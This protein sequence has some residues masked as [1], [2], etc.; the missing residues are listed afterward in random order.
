M[1]MVPSR[2]VPYG[3]SDYE[4]LVDDAEFQ[5]FQAELE[6]LSEKR[7]E[8]FKSGN[9]IRPLALRAIYHLHRGELSQVTQ[10]HADCVTLMTAVMAKVSD[11]TQLRGILEHCMEA[12]ITSSMFLHFLDTGLILQK[13]ALPLVATNTEYLSGLCGFAKE[14]ERYAAAR[15]THRDVLSVILCRDVVEVINSQM[16]QFD[17]RNSPLRRKYDGLKYAVKRLQDI[18]YELSLTDFEEAKCLTT[19]QHTPQEASTLMDVAEMEQIRMQVEEYDATRDAI[20]KRSRDITKCS[21]NAIYCLHRDDSKKAEVQLSE[22]KTAAEELM[23]HIL[24][25]R[26]LRF[27]S[28]EGGL[29]EYAEALI[30]QNFLKSGTIMPKKQIPLVELT[31]YIGGLVDFTGEVGRYAVAKATRREIQ[32]VERCHAVLDRLSGEMLLLRVNS[33]M[34]KKAEAL[35]TNLR[36]LEIVLYELSLATA[37]KRTKS[38]STEPPSASKEDM[39]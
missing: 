34:A 15:A 31:E 3:R 2:P 20:I 38:E 16:M 22:A 18:L 10:L 23:P 17:F 6:R 27:G 37:G 7:D 24:A 8:C 29:E 35:A 19:G 13:S 39:E 1:S 32:A 21:K 33:Q 28:F 25:D 11:N 14:L 30:F 4:N 9:K 5:E 12:F 26:T 36:K